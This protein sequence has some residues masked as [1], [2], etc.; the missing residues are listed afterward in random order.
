M[1]TH[2]VKTKKEKYCRA[3]LNLRTIL[4]VGGTKVLSNTIQG[5][6]PRRIILAVSLVSKGTPEA[7]FFDLMGTKVLRVFLHPIHSHH[8]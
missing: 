4:P 5:M 2:G 8:Y 1:Y 6:D 3:V 7:E